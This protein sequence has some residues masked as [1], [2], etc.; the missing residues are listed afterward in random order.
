MRRLAPALALAALTAGVV[1]QQIS[2]AGA[3]TAAGA[4]SVTTT[5]TVQRVQPGAD[6]TANVVDSRTVTLQVSQTRAL[7]SRQPVQVSWTGA[8]PTGG[9]VGDPNA[10]EARQQEYPFVLLECRGTDSATAP[11]AERLRPET[12][13]TGTSR[14]RVATDRDTGFGPWRLDRYETSADRKAQVGVPSPFPKQCDPSYSPGERWVHF[15]S[16]AGKDYAADGASCPSVPPESAVVD[17]A[18]QP[19]N[20]TY[21]VTHLD[22][23]GST[24]F[25]VWT[26]ED[27]A[28]LGCGGPITCSLVAVPIMGISCDP[29]AAAL[30]AADRPSGDAA[31]RATKTCEASGAYAAGQPRIGGSEDVAVSGALWWSASNW[32][33]RITVPLDFAPLNNVCDLTG[34]ASSVNVYGSELA[35]QL[36]AQ[37]RPAFCLD[38]TKT[39]FKHVQLGEPQA[40]NLLQVGTVQAALITDPPATG[41]ATP[42]V[43]APLAMTGFAISYVIDDAGHEPYTKLR[44]TPRLLA[45]LLT[46]SYPGI[47]P[48]RDEYLALSHNP[49][50][51]S[52]DPEFQA[53]NPGI[54]KGVPDSAAAST[55]LNLSSD[56]DVERALTS[57]IAADP[58]AKAWLAGAPDPWG[59]VV[60]PSYT[61]NPAKA[62]HLVLPVDNWPLRDSFEP[63]KYDASGVNPCLQAA[64]SPI[65]PLIAAPTARL[66]SI[67]LAMQFATSSA[68]LVC[69][70]VQ[71]Q[72][73][74]GAK[75]TAEGRQTPGFRFVLG[76]TSLGDAER[77][78]LDTAALQT[79]VAADADPKLAGTSGRTFV[80]P[81][82]S[83]LAAAARLLTADDKTGTW[84]FPYATVPTSAAGAAAYPGAML[85]SLA[86]PTSG[87]DKPTAK[88]LSELLGYA[89]AQGQ[90]Q[91]LAVGQTP[92]GYLPL[93]AANGL[94]AERAF[95]LAAAK[96]VRA[97]SGGTLLPSHPVVT[98]ATSTPAGSA[99]S[100]PPAEVGTAPPPV[101]GPVAPAGP[102]VPAVVLP[103]PQPVAAV[104]PGITGAV[105]S[106]LA[107]DLFPV[108]SLVSV[109][110]FLAAL[111]LGKVG[112]PRRDPGADT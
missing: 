70:T 46:E 100:R 78:D 99:A 102:A 52:Q 111:V 103:T 41:F 44:L 106:L 16:A 74:A 96:V 45:K 54:T 82:D 22:G 75:L 33:N 85:L 61:T 21:A 37:W 63:A 107:A 39:P 62:G 90:S 12:C 8:H 88:A 92:P 17:N 27:N 87:L 19:A 67:S 30:P 32:R 9:T 38:K 24:K 109:L 23:R 2:P 14:E 77:Y 57:Y 4:G 97:Q 80:S 98:P 53:L 65:L 25:T 110:A 94:G 47:T 15:V 58:E 68:Q 3:T 112:R 79:Q 40:R 13:W 11:A 83:S 56:S 64:P 81:S 59:M 1:V 69:Q 51:M 84:S 49:L 71:D 6:G 7:R 76:V 89:T 86:A 72:G 105:S 93:T 55:I 101:V 29:A 108:L 91:G 36:T 95:T 43:Q 60:N 104:S 10:A 35:T 5:R 66:A 50:D 28:S 73:A 18:S 48:V 20:T 34:G 31:A 42:T 26:S